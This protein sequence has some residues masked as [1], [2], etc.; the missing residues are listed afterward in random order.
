MLAGMTSG[1]PRHGRDTPTNSLSMVTA[2]RRRPSFGG[3]SV[4]NLGG[5]SM[6]GPSPV[7][8]LNCPIDCVRRPSVLDVAKAFDQYRT[9]GQWKEHVPCH[10]VI[11][12]NPDYRF[13]FGTTLAEIH[14]RIEALASETGE[15]YLV[16][17]RYGDRPVPASDLRFDD[18]TTAR[19]AAVTT[20]Q[21]RSAL[22][23][24]D[25]QVPYY[26]IIV[27]QESDIDS[28]A[29]R[30]RDGFEAVTSEVG[31]WSLT[32][33]VINTTTPDRDPLVEFCHRVAASVFETLSDHGYAAVESTVMDAYFELAERLSSTDDLCFC[34]LESMAV[35]LG[36][37]L[38][39][40]EQ[41][42]ILRETAARLPPVDSSDRPVSA[43]LSLLED[44]GLLGSY[45]QSPPSV[46]FDRGI[47]SVVVQISEYGLTPRHGHLPVLPLALELYRHQPDCTSPSIDVVARD[48]G[49]QLTI[50]RCGAT[51]PSGLVSAPILSGG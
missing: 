51:G 10:I 23:R 38:S 3:R 18:R 5:S 9:L 14:D 15:Y 32:E 8:V 35:D 45:T 21:Y 41:E 1:A 47:R 34:L 49:W 43:T 50:A 7:S 31:D 12:R 16:C 48:D 33:P 36:G 37:Q 46:D 29:T 17:A 11:G 26:D 13:M 24:Y 20:E 44:R 19:A 25:P 4:T 6:S 30:Q 40:D 39:P 2:S 42:T 28:G 22:R 27:C